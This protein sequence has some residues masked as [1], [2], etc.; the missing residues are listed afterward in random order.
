MPLSQFIFV[1]YWDHEGLVSGFLKMILYGYFYWWS[2][3][4]ILP[5]P[6]SSDKEECSCCLTIG[7]IF[8]PLHCGRISCSTI[9]STLFYMYCDILFIVLTK[10]DILMH[11]I[12][13]EI[14][15]SIFQR[16]F[17]LSFHCL[18]QV[19]R[20]ARMWFI[21]VYFSPLQNGS[22]FHFQNC[23]C[24]HCKVYLI[25]APFQLIK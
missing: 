11:L 3:P 24:L 2:K 9:F 12:Y 23:H 14:I 1:K 4:N 21:P 10:H 13:G 25:F 22:P 18:V 19:K 8:V 5:F 20:S 16:R 7:M 17:L 6:L 15:Y